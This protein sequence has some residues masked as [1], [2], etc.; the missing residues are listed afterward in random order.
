MTKITP[1]NTKKSEYH[2][3][4][5]K[6]ISADVIRGFRNLTLALEN[7]HNLNN[8]HYISES[9]VKDLYYRVKDYLP[10]LSTSDYQCPK[11]LI[12]K[13]IDYIPIAPEKPEN[14]HNGIRIVGNFL[15]SATQR[16]KETFDKTQR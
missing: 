7:L 16:T 4:N 8:D 14:L 1:N 13:I 12:Q 10:G 15:N 9:D 6:S 2:H 11:T 5:K 3:N